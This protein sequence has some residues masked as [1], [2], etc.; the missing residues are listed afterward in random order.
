MLIPIDSLRK[1]PTGAVYEKKAGQAT[2]T[3]KVKNDTVYISATCDSLHYHIYRQEE[4]IISLKKRLEESHQQAE[5][6]TFTFWMAVKCYLTG[7][8]IGI[9]LL[10]IIQFIRKK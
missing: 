3:A 9:A 6:V 2:V 5:T 1:L 10:L 4:K 8:L 7:A